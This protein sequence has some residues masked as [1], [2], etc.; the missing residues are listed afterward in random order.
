MNVGFSL[1]NIQPWYGVHQ[2]KESS[3]GE[4]ICMVIQCSDKSGGS[5]PDF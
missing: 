3:L 2:H 1:I 4:Y 5:V